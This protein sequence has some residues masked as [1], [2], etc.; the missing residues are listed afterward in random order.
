MFPF[1]TIWTVQVNFGPIGAIEGQGIRNRAKVQGIGVLN[2][3]QQTN[4][5]LITL[6]PE[7]ISMHCNPY[8]G[9]QGNPCNENR[10]PAMRTG[11]PCK[12]NRVFPV[13]I[14]F[15]LC[16]KYNANYLGGRP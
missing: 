7:E 12:E 1:K 2:S 14:D 8:R 4:F 3:N 6:F 9:L 11:V 13:G 15:V 5:S 10:D 16:G